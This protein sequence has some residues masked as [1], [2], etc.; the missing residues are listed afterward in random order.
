MLTRTLSL[1]TVVAF[2]CDHL[3]CGRSF[4]RHDNL[5]QHLK[6]HRHPYDSPT[7]FGPLERVCIP[8]ASPPSDANP[9]S[10]SM[11]V[12]IP[13]LPRMTVP[14]A[15]KMG[16]SYEEAVR[17]RMNEMSEG[18]PGP[19]EPSYYEYNFGYAWPQSDVR[20]LPQPQPQLVTESSAAVEVRYP[21]AF[22]ERV[23][24]VGYAFNA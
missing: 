23:P 9:V 24:V 4:T 3:N 6:N 18:T 15:N 13:P 10:P 14:S 12:L 1:L 21:Q 11:G 2:K 7:E 8:P 19:S 20:S 16:P 5:L 17:T 22:R